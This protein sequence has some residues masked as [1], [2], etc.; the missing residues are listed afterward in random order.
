[1]DLS[2]SMIIDKDQI[3]QEINHLNVDSRK[4]HTWVKDSVVKECYNCKVLFSFFLRKHHCRMCGK[5]YCYNCSDYKMIIPKCLQN[6]DLPEKTYNWDH[7]LKDGFN[8]IRYD[9]TNVNS[10]NINI[11][12]NNNNNNDCINDL[13]RVCY[14]CCE[15]IKM[16]EKIF[17]LI[18]IFNFLD[19]DIYDYITIS[20]VCNTWRKVALHYLSKFRE[21]QYH[22]P[23]QIYSETECRMLWNNRKY[24]INH[25]KWF[26]QLI[27]SI[28]YDNYNSR[29]RITKI[30]KLYK[31]KNKN[32]NNK[33]CWDLM[34]S[35]NCHHKLLPSDSL[36]LLNSKIK[37]NKLR[38]IALNI[39]KG[40]TLNELNCYLFYLIYEMGNESIEN[41]QIGQFLIEKAHQTNDINFINNI[42]W[43]I[44]ITLNKNKNKNYNKNNKNLI[45]Y[46]YFYHQLNDQF[47]NNS[48]F[49]R[50]QLS[51]KLLNEEIINDITDINNLNE[52]VIPC[53]PKLEINKLLKIKIG[54]SAS[55]PLHLKFNCTNGDKQKILFKQE[56]IRKDYIIMN[57]I[58]ISL[59]ILQNELN[60]SLDVL[61]YSIMPVSSK[62]GFIEIIK[63]SKTLYSIQKKFSIQNY[64]IEHNNH[65]S[66]NEIRDRFLKSCAFYTV[67]TYLL[68][69]GDRHLDNILI[70]QKGDLFH[71]DFGYILGDDPKLIAPKMRITTE[72]IDA[73]GGKSSKYYNEFI[74]LSND[75]FNCLRRHIDIYILLLIP[76]ANITPQI[77]NVKF[78]S[79]ERIIKELIKR[80]IPGENYAQAEIQL[81][82]NIENSSKAYKHAFSD[83][84]HYHKKEN[85][86]NSLYNSTLNWVYS[87]FK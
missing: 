6:N 46:Q 61:T 51:T 49:E 86:I 77:D 65:S 81:I 84:F 12:I 55:N 15:K 18:I 78:F 75:I 1:M 60:L 22:L 27:R 41:L 59:M 68:G 21:I 82:N 48:V 83:F 66:N 71:I 13:V 8:Y 2:Y 50:I 72:M 85:T 32:K 43:N 44:V 19:L 53:L 36:F 23:H 56:D 25:N 11:N 17:E 80:F 47:S 7:L 87:I 76:L 4:I 39:L 54:T 57:L 5:I 38:K 16:M 70:S 67:F 14:S 26:I 62:S 69:I 3:K 31:N 10:N 63:N 42:Y 20:K 52:I 24:L 58:K 30:I 33:E 37:C 40:A 28:D 45:I 35:R 34:C 79:K 9:K 74:K 29:K 64:L 73:L